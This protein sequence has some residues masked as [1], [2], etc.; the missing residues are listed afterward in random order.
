MFRLPPLGHRY[1]T[2]EGQPVAPP[3]Q[4]CS[5]PQGAQ[6]NLQAYDHRSTDGNPYAGFDDRLLATELKNNF[7]L[8]GK[9]QKD[10]RLHGS[11]L[12]QIANEPLHDGTVSESTIKLVQEIINR[13]RLNEAMLV[14]G[15]YITPDSLSKA[16]DLLPGNTSPF[17]YNLNPFYV[18]TDAQVV[19]AFKD[20]L[21]NV[22]FANKHRYVTTDMLIEM[23]KDPDEKNEAG[24]VVLDAANNGFPKKKYSMQQVYLARSLIER[25]GLLASLES[26]KANGTRIFGSHNHDGC[27]KSSSIERW[28][29]NDKKEKGN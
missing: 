4:G 2:G 13:P 17:T 14:K 21:D 27:L 26:N 25:P 8:L 10:G 19:E 5:Q 28:L 15:G 29:E 6:A 24:Q 16:A 23:S 11:A 3:T 12:R 1:S 7:S 20:M 9:F 22:L 18:E